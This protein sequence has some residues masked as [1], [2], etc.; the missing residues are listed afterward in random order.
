MIA[1]VD[2]GGANISSIMFAL[3]NWDKAVF[4]NDATV[5]SNSERVILPELVQL[6]LR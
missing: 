1:V 6:R 2:S 4:T 3:E 5:I